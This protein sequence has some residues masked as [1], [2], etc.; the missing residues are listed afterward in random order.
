M[1]CFNCILSAAVHRTIGTMPKIESVL[2]APTSHVENEFVRISPES[3]QKERSLQFI[4]H[5]QHGFY[6]KIEWV[7]VSRDKHSGSIGKDRTSKRRA[8]A[9]LDLSTSLRCTECRPNKL[10][11]LLR[12]LRS[13]DGVHFDLDLYQELMY[14]I[15][16]FLNNF[17]TR[18]LALKIMWRYVN[19]AILLTV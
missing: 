10:D 4:W 16:V 1:R 18:N 13:I 19:L 8:E 6:L 12:Y 15:N 11:W 2:N 5:L 9:T 17:L 14:L 7:I 3:E